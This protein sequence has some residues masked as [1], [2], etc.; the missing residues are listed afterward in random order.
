MNRTRTL[1]A[2]AAC[3]A[4]AATVPVAAASGR[5]AGQSRYTVRALTFTVTVPNES[6][7]GGPAQTCRIVGDLYTPRAATP[8]HRVP[9]I[10]TTNGFGG[11]K[12]DQAGIGRF[13]AAHG[14]VVLSYSGLG[15]GGSACKISLD[16]PSYDGVAGRQLVS[17]LGGKA[18]IAKDSSGHAVTLHVVKLDRRAH[19]GKHHAND[20]RVGM[21]GGSYGG[22]IQFAVASVD[23]RL[24]TIIPI[25]TWND[26][27]YSLAPNNTG[28]RTGVTYRTDAPGTEK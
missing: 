7:A 25:I 10:L 28:Q 11:S 6:V 24:D 17:F 20:P 23:P 27:A 16:D 5:A 3:A 21:I 12:S 2:V 18:G 8:R 14:Y 9:A 1:A 26:L 19:D 13:G 4:L 22:Q 15:F